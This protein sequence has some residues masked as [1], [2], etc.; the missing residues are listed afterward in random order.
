MGALH[1]GHLSLVRL[2]REHAAKVV[3]SVFVNPTQFGPNEDFAAYPRDEAGDAAQ[4]AD[5][6]CDLMF[7]PAVETMYPKGAATTVHVA[8]VSV[9][10]DGAARPGHFDGVATIVTKLFA[11]VGPDAAVFGEKD[12]QQLQVIRRFTA[13]LNLPVDIVGAPIIRADDGLA[14][15]SR[16]AYLGSNERGVAP[17]LQQ[18]LRHAAQRLRAGDPVS[19]VEAEART[20]LETAGFGPIDYVEVRAAADFARLGPGPLDGQP[21][22]LLA[23]ARLGKTRLIDNLAV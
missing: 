4:L 8:G 22:R 7:A 21:A 5:A 3:V 18:A 20:T 23:A 9:P 10:L 11:I 15:S 19:D 6:G 17:A 13:D 16:N 14:L 12:Y 1:A 2:A